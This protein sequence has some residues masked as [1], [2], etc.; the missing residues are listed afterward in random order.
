MPFACCERSTLATHIWIGRIFVAA[1]TTWTVFGPGERQRSRGAAAAAGVLLAG[2][3][4]LVAI[5][6]PFAWPALH[7]LAQPGRGRSPRGDP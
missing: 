2:A 5:E 7:G 3:L 4:A 6:G 1:A